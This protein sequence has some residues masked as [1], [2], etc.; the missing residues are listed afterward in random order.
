M[1]SN[2][3]QHNTID[4][5]FFFILETQMGKPTFV[6][7]LYFSEV[8]IEGWAIRRDCVLLLTDKFQITKLRDTFVVH[9]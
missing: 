4:N 1:C 6:W 9:G 2:K 7:G 3:T 8:S 5:I